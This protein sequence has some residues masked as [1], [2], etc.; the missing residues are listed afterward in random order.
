MPEVCQNP[1]GHLP[2]NGYEM[3][4]VHE[5]GAGY[6]AQRI[7]EW[8]PAGRAIRLFVYTFVDGISYK[9]DHE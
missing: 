6:S 9:P 7:N 3:I 5:Y 2:L 4:S 1:P 8:L